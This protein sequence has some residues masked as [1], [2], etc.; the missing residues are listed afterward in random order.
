METFAPFLMTAASAALFIAM[1]AASPALADVICNPRSEFVEHLKEKYDEQS[2]AFGL[3][4]DGRLLELF[5]TSDR[6]T[7]TLLITDTRGIS[8]VV[9]SGENWQKAIP[10]LLKPTGSP[11]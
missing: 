5:A 6:K 7:W 3:N 10:K 9:T 1:I 8:C 2:F 11:V 4:N